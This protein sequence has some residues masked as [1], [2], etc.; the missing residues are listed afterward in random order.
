MTPG[1]DIPSAPPAD[2][3][4]P[5]P[6]IDQPIAPAGEP[7][8]DRE[9]LDPV[10]RNDQ[11]ARPE[12]LAYRFP[13][14]GELPA[15]ER[16]KCPK[17]ARWAARVLMVGLAGTIVL[18]AFAPWQQTVKGSGDVTNYDPKLRPQIVQA[19]ITGRVVRLGEGIREMSLVKK[20]DL[21]CEMADL[22]P[23][24][25]EAMQ[26]MRAT[27]EQAR[28]SAENALQ[29][30]RS[31]LTSVQ[32]LLP[33]LESQVQSLTRAR[34]QRIAS[35]EAAL[36]VARKTREAAEALVNQRQAILTQ[37]EADYQRQR[38]LFDEEFASQLTYQTA[39]RA[40][41]TARADLAKAEADVA[42]ANEAIVQKERDRDATIESTQ[43][44]IELA[45]SRL[46]DT[47]AKVEANRAKVSTAEQS[48]QSA[49]L[50]LTDLDS[51]VRRQQNQRV[52]AP[53]DGYLVKIYADAG[54]SVVALGSPVARIVPDTEDRVVQIWLDGNDATLVE[55]GRHVRLQ[56]EGWP[57]VQFAGWPSV[58][59]GT[60]GGEVISVDATDDGEGRFRMLV[61]EVSGTDPITGLVEEPWPQGRFLRPGVRSNAWVLL[62]TVSLWWV[63]WRNLNGFPPVV[64]TNSDKPPKTPKLPKL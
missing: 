50:A 6:L 40:Y 52:V 32:G 62:E 26:T 53:I 55:P 48:L 25:L 30:A 29:F 64:D 36:E 31:E 9:I 7:V 17:I 54:S 27:R 58:A 45:K 13:K 46:Q 63:V 57:A 38:Q 61:K 37:A 12:K 51:S 56:F 59:V 10:P 47:R 20:G 35:A 15:L 3:T 21:I 42:A 49:E 11:D 4:Q 23:M 5:T 16:C 28:L 33:V 19:P 8:R 14:R 1:I 41:E 2:R 34:E 24:R 18:M 43:A 22:D 60:F 39:Q 44:D